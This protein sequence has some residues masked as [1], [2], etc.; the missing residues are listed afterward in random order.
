MAGE[1]TAIAVGEEAEVVG[2]GIVVDSAPVGVSDEGAN[3]QQESRFG[4]VEV[5]DELVHD[6]EAVAGFNH[7]LRLGME[8]VLPGEAEVIEYLA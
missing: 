6:A 4:L 5:G 8:G 2:E 7:Y 1:D 3:E